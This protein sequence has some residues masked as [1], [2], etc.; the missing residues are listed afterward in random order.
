MSFST[1]TPIAVYPADG[2]QTEFEISDQFYDIG[3]IQ[4]VTV[5]GGREIFAIPGVDFT[6]IVTGKDLTPP[7]R[8]LGKVKFQTPPIA[9]ADVVPFILP[10]SNQ[11]QPFEG[12]PVTPRQHERV[13]DRQA[14]V[15]AMLQEFFNR[16][17]RSPLNTP[18]A[19]RFIVAGRNGYVPT[20]DE[21]GNLIEGP[22][23]NQV[24]VVSQ[25]INQV[26]VVAGISDAVVSVAA[27]QAEV[28]GLYAVRASIAQLGPVAASIATLEPRAG[29]LAALAPVAAQIYATGQ[30]VPEIVHVS[31]SMGAIVAV[32]ALASAVATDR[33]AV[34]AARDTTASYLAAANADVDVTAA[35]RQQ[36]GLDR[37]ATA[38]D[39][40]ATGQDRVATGLDRV[41]AAASAALAQSFANA[42]SYVEQVLSEAQKL[43]ARTN[44]GA[45][46]LANPTFT[47][48]AKAPRL[49]VPGFFRAENSGTSS[50]I[51]LLPNSYFLENAAGHLTWYVSGA[52]IFSVAPTAFGN[53][54]DYIDNGDMPAWNQ[55]KSYAIAKGVG[56]TVRTYGTTHPGSA[57]DICAFNGTQ[58]IGAPPGQWRVMGTS[59]TDTVPG[60]IMRV[61]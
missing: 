32:P 7:F 56:A 50:I 17:Y 36:T 41:A 61:L 3:D 60:L 21:D 58:N 19:L 40:V 18:P 8:L 24:N 14:M 1:Y 15:T 13:H 38:A 52:P 23:V 28:A 9:G 33:V 12:R 54:K 16:S 37:I 51:E 11:D 5:I 59:I 39:R 44:I 2:I 43:V 20:W 10:P 35:N 55:L 53:L 46:P 57:F 45:A 4:V 6:V 27:Q 31:N 29:D 34:E 25:Y 47:G 49:E 26:V 30:A 22:T 42:V 48:V